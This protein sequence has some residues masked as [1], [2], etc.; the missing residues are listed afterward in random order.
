M[1]KKS[2]EIKKLTKKR[3]KTL[4]K[5]SKKASFLS[6]GRIF[7]YGSISF[8]RNIWLSLASTL[9]MTTTLVIICATLVANNILSSTANSI[10]EKIDITIFLKPGTK[11]ATLEQLADVLNA[12]PN[13]K[14]VKTAD[15][16]TEFQ[17]FLDEKQSE[18]ELIATLKDPEMRTIML[19]SIQAT[20][21]IKVKDLDRIDDIKNL[22]SS[23]QLFAEHL[24]LKRP[25]TYDL[26]RN[27]INTINSWANIAKNTGIILAVIFLVISVLVI[28]NTV[29]LAIF[30]RREEIYM[31]KLV[32]ASHHFIRGPFLI[33]A[34]ISGLLAGLTAG[35]ISYFGLS[36]LLPHLSSYGVDITEIKHLLENLSLTLLSFFSLIVGGIIIGTSSALLALRKYLR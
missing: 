2:R 28:F 31:M 27:E 18:K 17:A 19:S 32:G 7:K 33:E 23:N 34:E 1:E 20:I 12:E 8:T 24:D 9:I 35:S 29:R 10:R 30:S 16:E 13:V 21:R 5:N 6:A 15:S 25:P 3:L 36:F 22:V 4:S 11:P 14:S 26:N